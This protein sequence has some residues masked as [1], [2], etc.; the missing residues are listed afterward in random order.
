[1]Q[2]MLTNASTFSGVG[3]LADPGAAGMAGRNMDS[4]VELQSAVSIFWG[5]SRT[6]NLITYLI[7]AAL[8][9][10]CVVILLRQRPTG[11]RVWIALAAVAPLSML[12][13]YHLQHDAKLLLLTV[14]ACSVLWAE[15][16]LRGRLAVLVTGVGIAVNGDI[17]S[18]IRIML[19][20]KFV[21]P[22]PNTWSRMLTVVITR[23][24]PIV[25]LAMCVFYLWVYLRYSS[26]SSL[27]E[28]GKFSNMGAGMSP[29]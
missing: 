17:F 27:N 22:Q 23:P 9:L 20:H 6:Y 7:C 21:M 25:L 28:A 29:R 5:D 12:P 16:G 18:G 4:I 2:E 10:V 15:N 1:M 11:A 8:L 14:P 13:I 3:G 19:T 26:S 24:A